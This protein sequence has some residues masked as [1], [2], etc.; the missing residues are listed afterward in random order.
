MA[1][2]DYYRMLGVDR[3]ADSKKIKEAYRELAFKYHPDRNEKNPDSAEMMKQINEAYAVLSNV[4]K[5][6][7]Y[8]SMRNRFGENAYGQFRNTY[9]E[10]D[11]FNG[12]D[13][14]QIF[15]EMARSFGLRGVDGIFKDFYGNNR[16]RCG[17]PALRIQTAWPSRQRVHL[18]WWIRQTPQKSHGGQCTARRGRDSRFLFQKVTGVSLPKMGKIFTTPSA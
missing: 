8:D 5:R 11:I 14:H 2:Q 7:T 13:V 18:S 10:Q 15:E 17:M 12:S 9:T 4:E 16:S 3:S 6:R 1:Q